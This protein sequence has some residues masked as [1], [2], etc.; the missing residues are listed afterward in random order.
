MIETINLT[1]SYNGEKVV[2]SLNLHIKKGEV[3]GFLGPNGAGKTT[4]IAMMVGLIDP[5]EGKCLINGIDVTRMPK[6]AKKNIGYLPDGI[7]FYSLL[8]SRQNLRYCA[9][10]YDLDREM[11]NKRIEELLDY[12]GLGNNNKPTSTYSRGMKQ[13]LGIAQAL[14]NNPDILFLDEP[15]NGLDPQ[16]IILFRNIIKD[17]KNKGKT[18]FL[19]SHVLEEIK[20][21]CTAIG[22]I[23]KGKLIANGT[24]EEVRTI[25]NKDNNYTITLKTFEALPELKDSRIID[26]TKDNGYA[27]IKA[28]SDIRK[29]ISDELM[30]HRIHIQELS[31]IEKSLEEIFIDT[32]YGAD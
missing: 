29:E 19:S 5:S 10:F 28:T 27:I 6:Q 17:L 32:V 23:S 7:G 14:L 22:I 21:I 20:Q 8:N 1:K 18:V 9:E 3:Y 13:R 30:N 16:G 25:F 2:N 4:A 12:V 11:S 26:I 31:L 24:P 15:T